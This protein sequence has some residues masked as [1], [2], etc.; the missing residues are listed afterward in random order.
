MIA[1]RLLSCIGPGQVDYRHTQ[2]LAFAPG[3]AGA[4]PTPLV[5]RLGGYS[6]ISLTGSGSALLLAGGSAYFATA[7]EQ[8]F[9][10]DF[11]LEIAFDGA[12]LP[13]L[14]PGGEYSLGLSAGNAYISTDGG[15]WGHFIPVT[16]LGSTNHVAIGRQE[17]V[18]QAWVNGSRIYRSADAGPGF[19]SMGGFTVSSGQYSGSIVINAIRLTAG[20][21]LYGDSATITVPTLPLGIV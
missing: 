10:G 14:N 11:L 5:G 17:G 2:F 8:G 7:P 12:V 3:G 4:A 1:Q 20:V 13:T 9:S 19:P 15:S 18:V 6:G 21:N 16:P